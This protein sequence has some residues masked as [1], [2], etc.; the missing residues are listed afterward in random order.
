MFK[1][2][3]IFKA[4]ADETRLRLINILLTTELNVN[5]I[6]KIM[7][8]GQSRISRHL[9]ILTD[10]SLL[11]CRKD[12]L[13]SFYSTEDSGEGAEFI[14]AVKYRFE[15]DPVFL[16][17]QRRADEI[18]A[19]RSKESTEFFDSIASN[20]RE[21]K[22][23]IFGDTDINRLVID[24]I[25]KSETIVDLGCGT[26]D[27][28][29]LLAE[30]S[31]SVIGVDRSSEMLNEAGTAFKNSSVSL[32]IGELEHL[33]LRDM[34]ADSAVINMTMHHLPDPLQVLIE[35]QRIL[36]PASQLIISDL[37]SHNME[38]LRKKFGDRWL[39]FSRKQLESMLSKAGFEIVSFSEFDLK[40]DL[41]GFILNCKRK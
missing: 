35:I 3:E 36:K 38:V 2:V 14:E 20:W 9:K 8:M 32:R 25:D 24:S 26:G 4:M 16:E 41:K 12:G 13:W 27:L 21:L 34:E 19:L 17:D 10:S 30:K 40:K 6:L 11:K 23:E 7:E 29:P 33:P 1:T 15:N 39:G 28:L 22:T 18:V 31:S 37:L 5:E